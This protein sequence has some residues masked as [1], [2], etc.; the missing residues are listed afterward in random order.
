MKRYILAPSALKIVLNPN[1]LF[2]LQALDKIQLP[3]KHN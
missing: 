3:Q 1:F 2:L